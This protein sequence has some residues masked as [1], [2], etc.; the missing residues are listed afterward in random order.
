MT[1]YFHIWVLGE[2]GVTESWTKLFVVGPLPSIMRPIAVGLKSDIFYIKE[3][4][5]IACFDLSTQRIE[6]VG[7]KEDRAWLQIVIYKENLR[8][9]RRINN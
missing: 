3:D 5:E 2:L 8:S 1:A 6:E 7:I 4:K 9:F